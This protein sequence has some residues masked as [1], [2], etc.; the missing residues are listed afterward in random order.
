MRAALASSGEEA[1]RL[2][3]LAQDLLVLASADEG[4]LP[5]APERVA[6]RELLD[7]VARSR[8]RGDIVVDAPR[9]LTVMADR[10]R[11]LQAVRT[12]ST[13]R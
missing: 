6:V 12:C 2:I 10:Q 3:R 9:G 4:K 13:T 11:L 1:D 8:R 5:I 7:S